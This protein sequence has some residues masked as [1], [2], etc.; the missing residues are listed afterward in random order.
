MPVMQLYLTF[1]LVSLR[2]SYPVIAQSQNV[3]FGQV[4]NLNG[5]MQLNSLTFPDN[6]KIETFSQTQRQILVNQNPAPVPASHV[7]GSTGQPFIQLSQN[8]LTIST[9]NATDLVGAQIEMPINAAMLQQMN[10]TPDN[11][12]VAMLSPNRQAWIIM[13]GQKSVNTTDNTVRMVKM[14]SIDGE[15]MAVGRQTVETSNVLSPFG[16]AQQQSVNITGSGIQEIE[17]QDGFRMSIMASKPMTINTDVV[18]GVSTSMLNGAAMPVNNYR[19]LVTTNLAGVMTDLNQMMAVVQLPLNAN[20]LMTMA[21]SMGAGPNDTI[22]LGISQR[23]VIQ[24][25]GGA[26]GGNLSP[27]KR[28][29]AASSKV[30]SKVSTTSSA[31]AE[32]ATDATETTDASADTAETAASATSKSVK[33][34]SAKAAGAKASKTSSSAA[35]EATAD[36]ADPATNATSTS[37]ATSTDAGVSAGSAAPDTSA[38]ADPAASSPSSSSAAATT[39]AP[40]SGQQPANTSPQNPAATQ[41]LLSPTFTPV[42]A[43]TVL[44]MTNGRV[45]VTVSQLDGEFI[46]TMGKAGA[47]NTAQ[48]S[49]GQLGPNGA[50][51]T[52]RR[53]STQAQSQTGLLVSMTEL[54]T[55]A[56]MQANGGMLQVMAMMDEM[57][58]QSGQASSSDSLID[59]LGL[60]HRRSGPVRMPYTV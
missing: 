42:S 50:S 34:A 7:M 45:A 38:S 8:S 10:I 40:A 1:V 17:Y 14:N 55:L 36:S 13:E 32:D 4:S 24:N 3:Q 39:P 54:R 28:Q 26:T 44:D 18:N 47:Q 52:V 58:S 6:S 16:G 60:R 9:N 11:T 22:S 56:Q 21:Q 2:L 27:Q 25:P 49:P 30:A 19:Y 33:T 23:S 48:A 37:N 46:V 15:Y 5:D 35:T 29:K 53:Q 57:K 59:S 12:F 51:S 43:R 31:E 20:R 41:L